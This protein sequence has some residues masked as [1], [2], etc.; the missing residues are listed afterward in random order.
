MSCTE[1]NGPFPTEAGKTLTRVY[2]ND[3]STTPALLQSIIERDGAVIVKGL[4]PREL[5]ERVREDLKPQF[6]T[7]RV[8]ESGFFPTTT[9]RAHGILAYSDATAELLVNPLFQS[10]AN[11]ILTS[12]YTYWEGQGKKR[13]SAK[14]QIASIVGFRVEPGGTQQ[15]LHR[16]DADYHTKN[17]DMPVMLGCVTVRTNTML[18]STF[19]RHN[20]KRPLTGRV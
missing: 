14:P 16:D 19:R 11:G 13:V 1:H 20:S 8:D 5:C 3:A 4:V 6:D 18:C 12:N 9:K 10:V 17:C 7:D 2:A 15:A